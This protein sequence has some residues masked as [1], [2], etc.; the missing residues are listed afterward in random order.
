MTGRTCLVTGANSG[1]GKETALG[2]ARM[3]ARVVLVCRNQQK[4]ESALADIQRQTGSSHLDLLI[5]DMSSFGSVRGLAERVQQLYPQLDVLIN[6]AGAAVRRRTLSADGIEMTVAGNYLGAALLTFL[7]LDLLKS[8]APSRIVNVSSEAQ[9]NSRL[10]LNDLQ[11]EKRKYNP[12][13][14]YGQ[15]KLLMNAFTF[16]LA[17]RLQGTG[18]TANCLHPGVVATNIW[19]ADAPWFVKLLVG[20]MK[21]FMLNSKQ[22]AKVSLYLATSPDVANVSGQYFVKSRPANSNPLSRDPKV[23]PAIWQWTKKMIGVDLG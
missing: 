7:L 10:D 4:G 9:R 11:F 5:A 21:P 18:V 8:S 3:G 13:A 17:R 23:M 19:P 12:L 1:I 6:N 20:V 16:E 14:A 15:S 22:G 2:L